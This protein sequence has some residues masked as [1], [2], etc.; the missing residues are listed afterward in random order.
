MTIAFLVTR[1]EKPSA[2]YRALQFFPSLEKH[3]YAPEVH[4]IPKSFGARVRLLRSMRDFDIVFLQKKLFNAFEFAILRRNARRLIYD[5]DDA[6]MFRDPTDGAHCSRKRRDNFS[7]T[8]RGSDAVIAGNEYL[9]SF[10]A[11]ENPQTSVIPTSLEM[12]RY[13][14]RPLRG[15]SGSITIGW[16]GSGTTLFYLERMKH[17]WDAIFDMFPHTV[18][19]IVADRFFECMRMPVIKKQW[20]YAEE[21]DD[22]HSFDIGVM[23]LTDDPWSRGKC[24]F[25]LLQY[26][27]AGIPAV[28]SPVGT[29]REII[30]EGVNGFWAEGND[31]WVDKVGRLI[32]SAELRVE[33]G[34]KARA[35][36]FEG[37]STEVSG[38]KILELF[39]TLSQRSVR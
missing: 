29:N 10:A 35:T 32:R 2:R 20:G 11:Q 9:R 17:V 31:E 14:E 21:I 25:K 15:A 7:R 34:R 23:P 39:N 22:L 4:V 3:G 8:V 27:A 28:C 6:V 24:G 26:M 1:L 30:T 13:V 12:S 36:V 38:R 5:F 37:Y 19:K 33:M 16:I 18:L